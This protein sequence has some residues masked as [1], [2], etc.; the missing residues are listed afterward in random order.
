[1]Q[2]DDLTVRPR[3]AMRRALE[4]LRALHATRPTSFRN[5]FDTQQAQRIA[6]SVMR[7]LAAVGLAYRRRDLWCTSYRIRRVDSAGCF[8]VTDPFTARAR[9]RVFPVSEDESLFLARR[10]VQTT[11]RRV[12]DIGTGSGVLG[13]AA[14]SQGA[15]VLA[16]DVNRKALRYAAFNC[17]LNGVHESI[18]LE[19]GDVF[20]SVRGERFDLIVS[21]P[22]VIPAPR[23]SG[24]FLHSDGGPDGTD[25]S[26]RL[27]SSVTE[28]L[29]PNGR[30]LI[31]C[32]SF[33]RRD[34]Q[35]ALFDTFSHVRHLP[36]L[37]L[38]VTR[39]YRRGLRPL[40]RLRE[41]FGQCG[42][43]EW[44]GALR[45]QGYVALEYMLISGER[46][47][48]FDLTISESRHAPSSGDAGNGS[49]QKRLERLFTAYGGRCDR[50]VAL[51][52]AVSGGR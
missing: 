42:E 52:R 16:I 2:R 34:G 46:S 37:K 29:N 14:A 30:L 3:F 8:V 35:L 39:L 24:F 5:L 18:R 28:H 43:D 15:Q 6:D 10:I 47:R 21:N 36:R 9:D 44:I 25:I 41:R 49:W 38:S 4:A 51:G 17:A 7:P 45:N 20:S 12:L 33:V 31:L 13:L 48:G 11:A 27:L 26:L 23:G 32:T 22:P 50:D 1:M 40:N 19:L